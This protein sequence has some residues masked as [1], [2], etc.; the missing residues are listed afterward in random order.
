[1]HKLTIHPSKLLREDNKLFN[2]IAL[3]VVSSVLYVLNRA[4]QP[5][6]QMAIFWPMNAIMVGLFCRF[7]FLNRIYYYL[8]LFTILIFW[9]GLHGG[10]SSASMLITISNVSFVLILVNSILFERESVSQILKINALR[11][12][13]YCMLTA[14][15]CSTPGAYGFSRISHDSFWSIYPVWFS[16]QFSTSVLILPFLLTFNGQLFPQKFVFSKL[17]PICL[18]AVTLVASGISGVVGS[19]SVTLPA[20][21][22]CA[23]SYTLPTT[24][25][26]TLIAGGLEVLMV[27]TQWLHFGGSGHLM[28]IISARMGISSIAISPVIVAVSVQSINTLVKQL[29]ARANY[30]YLTRVHSRFGLYEKLRVREQKSASTL[31]NVLLLDIDHFKSINDTHGHDCGDNVLTAFARRVKEVV[32]EQGIVARMGGEEFA[33]VLPDASDHNG[34]LLAEEIRADIEKMEVP[35]GGNHLSLTVSIG[36]SHGE[37]PYKELVDA[38]DKLLS[39]ADRYLYQSK[40]SGRNRTSAAPSVMTKHLAG[41]AH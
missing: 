25:L 14:L 4:M 28:Q 35:W 6:G 41:A 7:S 32:G 36:V 40:N 34:F 27:D 16:E 12:Y 26:I 19:L 2:T 8:T 10:I 38:F 21:I 17:M 23:L 33:V 24:C 31:L 30:D 9:D 22:W 11:L 1:M 3:I 29:S 37:A 39:E 13:S 5:P 15:I 20:L 18:L